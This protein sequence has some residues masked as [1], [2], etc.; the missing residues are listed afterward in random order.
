VIIDSSALVAIL[1]EEPDAFLYAD[2][3]SA[4]RP[5]RISAATYLE[6]AMVIDGARNALSSRQ[7][8]DL[9]RRA[10]VEIVPVTADQAKIARAAFR[11]FGRG[12][13]HAAG[14]N[15]GDCF[16]YAL[17]KDLDEP[18]LFK[19]DDFIHTDVEPALK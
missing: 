12:S 13:G 14:L 15:Y 4:A 18:L 16:V 11:D 6:T 7:F 10:D 3:I 2:A 8:D 17:A 1:R 9:L 19:G 5:R